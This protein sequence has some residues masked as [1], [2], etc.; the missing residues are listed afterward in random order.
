MEKLLVFVL[1]GLGAQLVDGTLGMAFGVTATTLFIL[2]GT[3]AATASAVVHV[4]EVGTT[5]VSGIS[6]WRFGNVDWRRALGLGVPGAIGA[7]SGATFLSGLDGDAAKPVTSA[8]LLGLGLWVV[9]RFAFLAGRDRKARG[10]GVKKLAPLGLLGGLLDSTGGGGW[11]PITTSTLL[12]AEADRPRKVIGTVSAAEFLVSAAAVVGFLPM[13]REE[14]AQHAAPVIGLLVG[15][16]IAAPL[17]AYL[18]G[19]INPRLLGIVIGGVLVGL[20]VR[21][22]LSGVIPGW[23]LAGVLSVWVAVI[24]SLVLWARSHDTLRAFR[25]RV[26]LVASEAGDASLEGEQGDGN[27]AVEGR[28]RAGAESSVL[29]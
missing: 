6:H 28:S 22:L 10:W 5:L 11:G 23:G 9:I 17:A 25:R 24:V 14:F 16:V 3:G 1:I 4:A 20:N 15:G 7:F 21:T 18:V 29:Q 2:S 27:G 26:E 13:L 8:I 19:R 12:S